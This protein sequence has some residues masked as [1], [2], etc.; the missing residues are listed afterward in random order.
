MIK[1]ETHCHTL[2]GSHC[3]LAD[4]KSI[5]NRYSEEGYNGVV[6]TNHF[7]EREFNTYKGENK[8]QKL[9][10]YF[11]LYEEVKELGEKKGLRIFL[12]SEILAVTGEEYLI[13][14]FD[15][16]LFYDNKPLYQMTQEELFRLAEKN[17]CFFYQSHPFRVKVPRRGTIEYLHGAESFNGHFHHES[18]NHLAKKWCEENNLIGIS[19]TDF[20]TPNQPITAGIFTPDYVKDEKSLVECLFKRDFSLYCDEQKYKVELEKFMKEKEKICK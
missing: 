11:T 8:K 16:S 5:V 9:D 19:G 10:F 20:H 14:G 6:I 2:Y 1:L 12:G 18:N 7:N 4:A 3:G 17:G 15:K 13:Y